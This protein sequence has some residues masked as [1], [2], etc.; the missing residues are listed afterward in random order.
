MD[1]LNEHS[2]ETIILW[3]S[4]IICYIDCSGMRIYAVVV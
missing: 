3:K 1:V 2:I 4:Y